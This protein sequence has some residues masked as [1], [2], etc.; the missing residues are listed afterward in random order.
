ML[1][2]IQKIKGLGVFANYTPPAGTAEFGVKNLIYGWNYSGKTT[3]SRLFGLLDAKKPNPELPPCT[4]A[5]DSDQGLVTE[6]NFQ[7]CPHIVRV[8]NSDFV[9]ENLNFAGTPFKPILLLGAESEA[10]QKEIDRCEELA[11]RSFAG[12]AAAKKGA[13]DAKKALDKAKTDAAATIKSTMSLVT[14]FGATQLDKELLT[15]GLGL[16]DYELSATALDADLKLARSSDQDQLAAVPKVVLAPAIEALH[17]Q[18]INLLAK[19]PNLASTIDHLVKNP[20]VETWVES[21]L[22]LHDGKTACEFC[23]GDLDAH[24]MVSIKAH[25]SKDLADHKQEVQALLAKV[26]SATLAMAQRKD[27]ELYAQFR[28]RFASAQSDTQKAIETFNAEVTSLAD[29]LRKKLQAPFSALT[30]PA[31]D[32]AKTAAVTTAADALNEVI[33]ENNRVTSNFSTEKTAAINRL[34]LHYAQAFAKKA[35]IDGYDAGQ[36][37]FARR[38]TKYNWCTEQL[39][40]EIR[41]LK[42][43]ISQAQRGREEINKRIE[44]L[45]GSESVQISVIKVGD[46]ERFQLVRR[47]GKPAKHLSEGEKTAIAFSFFLTK[48]SEL[49]KLDEA[50]VYVD[51][52]ISSLDSNHIFQVTA[53]VKETFFHKDSTGVWNTRCKQV[54]FSTHNFEFFSLLRD[55]DPK[56]N[57]RAKHY[58]IRRVSPHASSFGNMP[59]S[60][61]GYSSEYHFLF[62]VLND[63]HKSTDKSDF[64]VLMHLPNAVRRFVELYTF[65]KYPSGSVDA[66]ADRIFGTEKSKRILKV[67]HY[68]SH[69]NNI[70]RIAQNSDLI[71]DIEGAVNDLMVLLEEKDPLHMEALRAAVAP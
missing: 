26:E 69:A 46:Q 21:G 3:L 19:T 32:P 42:A 30:P 13:E 50:I 2:G 66:R 70:E 6:T 29:E 16:E 28:P 65:A 58:L 15:V 31:L 35:D 49:K 68:F 14:F 52:P 8:F 55:L 44:T 45:L 36:K 51:D 33:G 37:S 53:M 7:T 22:P 25:F 48:L 38:Q 61:Y 40:T 43:I 47:D 1:K 10:A 54:F 5:I 71:C 59:L 64:N 62:D 17:T 63:F 11:K 67:L 34:K 39:D 57:P 9:A 20:L 27:V 60:M 18:A 4:F 24:R 23:G 41:R 56:K 12:A